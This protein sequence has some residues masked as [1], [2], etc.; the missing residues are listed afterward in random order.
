VLAGAL[1]LAAC[2]NG[3]S[4][5]T[6][7]PSSVSVSYAHN[8][9]FRNST[10]LV[11]GNNSFGQLGVG[12][13][14]NRGSLTK[15]AAGPFNLQGHRM[16]AVHT[17]AFVDNGKAWSWGYNGYGQLGKAAQGDHSQIP[18]EVD[19]ITGVKAVAAGA[20]HSLALLADDTVRA[21]GY[22]LYGQLGNGTVVNASA[23]VQS[24]TATV[25]FNGI[26][27]IAAGGHHSLALA[28]GK[29]WAWGYNGKGQLAINPVTGG[30]NRTSPTEV[31]FA[32]APAP[33]T[34]IAAGG[35]SSYAVAADG[36]LW[37]WGYNEEGE[38]GNGSAVDS[39]LPV[40]VVRT[41]AVP[42][43]P[44]VQVAAGLS[45]GLALTADGKVWAWGYN[46]SGQ[47][48]SGSLLD[49]LVAVPVLT[50]AGG[51]QLD[52]VDEV[53]AFGY[54]SMARKGTSWY[55][56]GENAYGQL[57]VAGATVPWPTLLPFPIP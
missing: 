53:R 9:L 16:G 47:L 14:G 5:P 23:P 50:A 44:V 29:V 55:V 56:W 27:R 37:A 7:I 51:P 1:L 39:H 41:G 20:Y 36:F 57:G 34:A 18:V 35:A 11:S 48:A 2:S 19:T 54:S 40:Q 21:W 22:N 6:A 43:G 13:L 32:T 4:T 46:F 15:L 28:G 31:V 49:S 33:F 30:N 26:T 3:S 8:A 45:H 10:T 12:D 42:L 24:V 17:V 38:L 52:G 25:G